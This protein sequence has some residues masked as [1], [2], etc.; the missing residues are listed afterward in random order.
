M[1]N[2]FNAL[3]D[4]LRGK[5][6]TEAMNDKFFS[7]KSVG[8][9]PQPNQNG[10]M[11]IDEPMI[12]SENGGMEKEEFEACA[13]MMNVCKNMIQQNIIEAAQ[14]YNIPATEAIKSIEAWVMGL[15]A[16]PF[17]LFNFESSQSNKYEEKEF[18]MNVTDAAIDAVVNIKN[19]PSLKDSVVKALRANAGQL[20]KY[21]EKK[22]DFKFFG[23][24]NGYT[25]DS[26]NMRVISFTLNTQ[27]IEVKTFCGGVQK[28]NLTSAYDSYYFTVDKYIMISM[29]KRVKDKIIDEIVKY[30]MDFIQ[31]M[32]ADLYKNYK[33]KMD[34]VFKNKK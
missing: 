9:A 20:G 16:F 14:K 29:Y 1:D 27:N 13:F 24:I 5:E 11:S 30:F 22:Q 15:S 3:N 2:E 21:A 28:V 7:G 17:P 33:S 19:V 12:V 26:G 8:D 32:Y 23:V 31:L 18:S 4:F 6:F 10:E 25:K 34:E